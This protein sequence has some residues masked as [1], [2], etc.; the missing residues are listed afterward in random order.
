MTDPNIL[1]RKWSGAMNKKTLHMRADPA[2]DVE[3]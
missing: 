2:Y 3:L 1:S